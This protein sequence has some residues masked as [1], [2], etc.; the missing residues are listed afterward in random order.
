MPGITTRAVP[1]QGVYLAEN[2]TDRE[3]RIGIFDPALPGNANRMRP[4]PA[5]FT[6]LGIPAAARCADSDSDWVTVDEIGYLECTCPEYCDALRQLMEKK[7]VI[8]AVRKQELPF[9]RALRERE[10][11]FLLDLDA[12]FGNLGC[13]IMAS[14]EG[15]RFGGN[16][17]TAPF[18]GEPMIARILAATAAIKHRV[19][20]TRHPE[21]AE[22]CRQRSVPAVLHD[23][24]YRSD[25]VRLGLEAL[26]GA[27][28]CMF[29]PGDQP[30]L[31]EET[32]LAMAL[33]SRQAPG[34]IL[35]AAA[36][37]EPGAPIL[38]PGEFFPELCALPAGKG[39]SFLAKKYPGRVRLLPVED[40]SELMDADTPEDL[41]F[42]LAR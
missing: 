21:V 32:V 25:T 27:E 6:G 12:P 18:H 36:D 2:G 8:A 26:P 7:R 28:G 22:L 30:L 15:K 35:R 24:P 4:D 39:G 29:C 42:L 1:G 9:L 3:V 41:A 19:V 14:G 34:C 10:D 13:V 40:A 17:L 33:L 11:V 16:K 23:L 37:G 5:G 38:F 20:V 31:R